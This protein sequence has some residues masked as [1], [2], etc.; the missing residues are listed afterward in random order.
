M[1][2]TDDTTTHSAPIMTLL[3]S[4]LHTMSDSPL[5]SMRHTCTRLSLK[6][7][8]ALCDVAAAVSSELSLRQRQ[9]DA[10]AKKD[11]QGPA[12][13]KR[14]A[15]LQAKCEESQRKKAQLDEMLHKTL[16]T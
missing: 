15:D 5:R 14:L 3:I 1:Y 13:K 2:E 9:R 10:E 4:W 7:C 11:A 6:V 16:D 8:T 12:G